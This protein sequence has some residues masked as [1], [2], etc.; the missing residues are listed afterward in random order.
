ML[1]FTVSSVSI[2][3]L[4]ILVTLLGVLLCLEREGKV[5][6][7]AI[8]RSLTQELNELKYNRTPFIKN[9][10]ATITVPADTCFPKEKYILQPCEFILR[11]FHIV[12]KN[13]ECK[14]YV[15]MGT[16][17]YI[18]QNCRDPFKEYG[19]ELCWSKTNLM[20]SIEGKDHILKL[21]DS[22]D[23]LYV[24]LEVPYDEIPAKYLEQNNPSFDFKCKLQQIIDYSTRDVLYMFTNRLKSEELY[25]R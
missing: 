21:R 4:V 23:E 2:I 13:N 10:E 18:L 24:T 3:I 25:D 7:R 6:L 9:Q 22:G 5:Y 16:L 15:T 20:H 17:N 14:K 8:I 19:V 12:S 1:E 11:V